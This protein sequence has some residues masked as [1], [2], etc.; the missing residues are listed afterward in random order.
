MKILFSDYDGTL[1]IGSGVSDE[2][3]EAVRAWQAAGNLFAM[4]SGRQRN[5]L[6]EELA[7]YGIESDYI[8]CFNGAEIFD[9]KGECLHRA[10]IPAEHLRGLY[11]IISSETGWANVC[12]L[13]RVERIVRNAESDEG[14]RWPSHPANRLESFPE[15]SQ[16]CAHCDDMPAAAAV[17]N[18]VLAAFGDHVN[19]EVNGRS[20]DVNAKGVSKASGI[21]WLAA[22]LGIAEEDIFTVG[23]NFNDLCMLTAYQGYAIASGPEEVQRQ[24]KGIVPSVAALIKSIL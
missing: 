2:N 16:I 6:C 13:D 5:N 24:A 15:F 8:L 23:D 11:D 10:N 3:V 17:R 1:R 19:A 20:L 22:H 4:A 12:M 14:S 7:R 21:A 9:R 18:R